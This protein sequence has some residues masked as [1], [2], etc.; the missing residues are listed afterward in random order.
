MGIRFSAIDLVKKKEVDLSNLYLITDEAYKTFQTLYQKVIPQLN[1]EFDKEVSI[2]VI[3]YNLDSPDQSYDKKKH[4][5]VTKKKGDNIIFLVFARQNHLDPARNYI[6]VQSNLSCK[7]IMN[8]VLHDHFGTRWV[9]KE[10]RIN[11]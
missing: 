3:L 9:K 4:A 7:I 8:N 6:Q 2:K 11:Y 1:Q 10:G 5:I